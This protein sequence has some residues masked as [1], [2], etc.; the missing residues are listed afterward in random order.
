M[1][2]RGDVLA[3]WQLLSE[4]VDPTSLP[5]SA[6]KIA[7][8]RLEY[9][10]YEGPVSRNRGTVT[11]VDSGTVQYECFDADEAVIRLTGERLQGRFTLSGSGDDWLFAETP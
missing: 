11:R 10:T 2:Q 8:H 6:R 1:L 9:L 5:V 4:P 7:D 3:T